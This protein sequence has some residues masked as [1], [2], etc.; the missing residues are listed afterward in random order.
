MAS[1]VVDTNVALVAN[2]DTPQAG[3]ACAEACLMRLKHVEAEERVVLDGAGL[4]LRE[5][6]NQRPHEVPR[7]PGDAFLVWV[8]DNQVNQAHCD[9]VTVTPL[10]G[11]ARG[12]AEFPDDPALAGFDPD[13]R[14][15]VAVALAS[16]AD[17]PILNASDTDWWQFRDVLAGHGVQVVFLCPDLMHHAEA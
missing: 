6:L 13:D 17:P 15:F 7:G 2:G 1:V 16:L 5:Y 3:P 11:E 12:F 10:P 8:F 14:K 4:I 9:I